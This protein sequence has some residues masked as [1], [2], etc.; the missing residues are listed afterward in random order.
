MESDNFENVCNFKIKKS[1]QIGNKK[2][3]QGGQ[4]W[5]LRS[6]SS[7]HYYQR[8]LEVEIFKNK[9]VYKELEKCKKLQTKS[10]LL[11]DLNFV[12]NCKKTFKQLW[13]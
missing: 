5:D 4:P 10:N 9:T 13:V 1:N 7:C 8:A 3:S 11:F 6:V 12:N 2:K